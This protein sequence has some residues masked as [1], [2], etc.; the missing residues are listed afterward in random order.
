M[1]F[2]CPET[3]RLAYEAWL[4]ATRSPVDTPELRQDFQRKAAE[5]L[6]ALSLQKPGLLAIKRHS[7][8]SAWEVRG[9]VPQSAHEAALELSRRLLD[10]R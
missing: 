10:S 8:D 1:N 2:L 7:F 4:T 6:R 9:A 5:A 3:L